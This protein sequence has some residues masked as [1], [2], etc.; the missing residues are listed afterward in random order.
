M[1]ELITQFIDF[2]YPPFRK[3]MPLQTFRYASCGGA[4]AAF[5]LFIYFV[6][7]QYIFDGTVFN[8]GFYAFKPHTAAVLFSS[9][10][11]FLIGFILNRYIVFVESNLR[12]RV[13]LFRY[14]LS[15]AFNLIINVALLKLFVEVLHIHPM[16][17]QVVTILIVIGISYITQR[18]FTFRI[19]KDGSATLSDLQ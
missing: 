1:K 2:F 12:G 16:I 6:G 14:F 10:I 3:F 13:Q 7:Y 8:I 4:N 11:T 5:G 15:F 9:F 17:S 18:H 19:N